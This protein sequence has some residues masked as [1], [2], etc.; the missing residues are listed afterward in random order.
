MPAA[1]PAMRHDKAANAGIFRNQR[2]RS[3]LANVGPK[4][5]LRIRDPRREAFLVHTPE[6]LEVLRPEIADVDGHAVIVKPLL[7]SGCLGR[8]AELGDRTVLLPFTNFHSPKKIRFY[9]FPPLPKPQ[10]RTY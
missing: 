6:F 7:H 8:Q 1:R 3:P 9:H 10:P 5:R 4:L 2:E